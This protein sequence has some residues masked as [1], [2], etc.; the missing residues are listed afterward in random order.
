M[1]GLRQ[2]MDNFSRL[3]QKGSDHPWKQQKMGFRSS[4]GKTLGGLQTYKGVTIPQTAL[5]G[6][7]DVC[8][9]PVPIAVV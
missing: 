6:G 4:K 5:S 1:E 8:I 2:K 3:P 9:P 7:Q